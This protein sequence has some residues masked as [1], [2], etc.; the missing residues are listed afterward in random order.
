M[1]EEELKPVIHSKCR[2]VLAN[3]V[4]LHHDNT[5]PHMAAVT[6]EMIQKL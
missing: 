1:F 3:G 6:I 2:G 5:Q 4:V